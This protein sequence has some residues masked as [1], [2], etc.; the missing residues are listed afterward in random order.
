MPGATLVL[1]HVHATHEVAVDPGGRLVQEGSLVQSKAHSA[2]PPSTLPVLYDGGDPA[3]A[4]RTPACSSTRW[5]S[6]PP[7]ELRD[8]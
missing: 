7:K 1:D 5:C 2:A 4:A 3:S 8:P 6:S